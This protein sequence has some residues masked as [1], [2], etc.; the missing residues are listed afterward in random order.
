[1]STTMTE[2]VHPLIHISHLS[3]QHILADYGL[4]KN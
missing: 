1:M 4:S 2:F 3:T